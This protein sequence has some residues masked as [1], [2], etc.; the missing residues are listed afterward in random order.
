MLSI[1][2]GYGLPAAL[3]EALAEAFCAAVSFFGLPKD[4]GRAFSHTGLLFFEA[5]ISLTLLQLL[6]I[7]S[8]HLAQP[9]LQ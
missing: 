6:L 4:F 1:K 3:A 5:I 9:F 7:C 8:N 2:F